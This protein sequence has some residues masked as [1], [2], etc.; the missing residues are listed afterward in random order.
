M[1]MYF[2]WLY[3]LEVVCVLCF[4]YDAIDCI[5]CLLIFKP[6]IRTKRVELLEAYTNYGGNRFVGA[7]RRQN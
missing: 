1:H 4:I 6:F 7:R 5:V 2:L 3:Q